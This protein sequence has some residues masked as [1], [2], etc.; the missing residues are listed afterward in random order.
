MERVREKGRRDKKLKRVGG[1]R[2]SELEWKKTEG[3]RGSKRRKAT[4]QMRE[5]ALFCSTKS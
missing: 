4:A 3:V 2:R 1:Y 5:R